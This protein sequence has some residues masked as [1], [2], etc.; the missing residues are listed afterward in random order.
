MP[1]TC[2]LT[3]IVRPTA[4]HSGDALAPEIRP[5]E[6]LVSPRRGP[7]AKR[8]PIRMRISIAFDPFHLP[9]LSTALGASPLPTIPP[10]T[11]NFCIAYFLPFCRVSIAYALLVGTWVWE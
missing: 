3:G 4:L 5:W 2:T 6:A 11:S 7:R 9:C 10:S 1:L 8:D